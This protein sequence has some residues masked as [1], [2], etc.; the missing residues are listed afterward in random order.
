M[1]DGYSR[2]DA[3]APATQLVPAPLRQPG[4][5]SLLPVISPNVADAVFVSMSSGCVT[6]RA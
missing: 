6:S 2:L 5:A 1:T 3:A 4:E